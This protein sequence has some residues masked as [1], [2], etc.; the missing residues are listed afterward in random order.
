MI[1]IIVRQNNGQVRRNKSR[2]GSEEDFL[3]FFT[4]TKEDIHSQAEP[5]QKE[6]REEKFEVAR[7]EFHLRRQTTTS[8][9]VFFEDFKKQVA[10]VCTPV[11][12]HFH[13]LCQKLQDS[14][15]CG[16]CIK[17]AGIFDSEIL[18]EGMGSLQ[19]MP[20]KCNHFSGSEKMYRFVSTLL[21]AGALGAFRK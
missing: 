16:G 11:Q 3:F 1:S 19:K 12:G 15:I 17:E 13:G 10:N 5:E 20:C 2:G 9:S 14:R 6:T 18:L 7:R 8:N 4:E 21:F